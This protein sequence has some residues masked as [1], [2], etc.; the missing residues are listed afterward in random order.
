MDIVF[1]LRLLRLRTVH[2]LLVLFPL[3]S[4]HDAPS[5]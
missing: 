4:S 2:V 5:F 3:S 1:L